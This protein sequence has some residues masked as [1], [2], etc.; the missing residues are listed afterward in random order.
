[1]PKEKNS[2]KK[3]LLLPGY[4]KYTFKQ[5][6]LICQYCN[7]LQLFYHSCETLNTHFD[8]SWKFNNIF[9]GKASRFLDIAL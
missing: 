3:A 4:C 6:Y 5:Y 8:D 9:G 7:I 1:M 2:T